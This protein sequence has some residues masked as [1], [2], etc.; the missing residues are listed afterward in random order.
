M[1]SITYF[2]VD[3]AK[4]TLVARGPGLSPRTLPNDDAGHRQLCALLP[5]DAHVIC[6]ATGGYERALVAALQR[7]GCAVSVLNPQRTRA[8][9]QAAGQRAKSDPIDAAELS[10]F[11]RRYEPAPTAPRSDTE[12]TLQ[13]LV[14]RRAQLIELQTAETNQLEHLE[15]AR[16]LRQARRRLKALGKDLA[17]LG[18]WIEVAI[19]ADAELTARAQRI[20]QLEGFAA[21]NTA[22]LLAEMPELG[23]ITTAKAAH[24]FGVAP[25]VRQS[26]LYK[27]Q[28]HI[29]GGRPAARKAL[30]MA[31]LSAV[32]HNRRLRDFYQGLRQRGKATKVA[33]VAVMRKLATL[34]NRLLRDPDFQLAA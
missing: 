15:D 22:I 21:V 13:E 9:A 27:G 18:Q 12:R 20:Q 23:S 31:A 28:S 6:E 4:A 3:I 24:L 30:Y 17:Q 8:A 33:L 16:L 26:G 29:A 5:P 10:D 32:V 34:L 19:A 25:F 2:G 1:N 14:R 7:A 11:G